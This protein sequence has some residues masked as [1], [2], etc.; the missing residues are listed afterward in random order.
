MVQ[1]MANVGE[2]VY[3]KE[4]SVRGGQSNPAQTAQKVAATYRGEMESKC[5]GYEFHVL[6]VVSDKN[7]L[8]DAIAVYYFDKEE[9]EGMNVLSTRPED[10]C[11]FD[12]TSAVVGFRHRKRNIGEPSRNEIAKIEQNQKEMIRKIIPGEKNAK[13]VVQNRKVANKIL[14]AMRNSAKDT[15][16]GMKWAIFVMVLPSAAAYELSFSDTEGTDFLKREIREAGEELSVLA[17]I[18]AV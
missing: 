4:L 7:S 12:C 5:A 16:P 17:V 18:L 3:K 6:S 8:N 11:N 1:T 13:D 10:G 15:L 9:D 2:S 14:M